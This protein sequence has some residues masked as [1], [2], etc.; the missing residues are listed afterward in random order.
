LENSPLGGEVLATF[1]RGQQLLRHSFGNNVAR[2]NPAAIQ[3]RPVASAQ[4][5]ISRLA[6]Q[7]EQNLEGFYRDERNPT[8]KNREWEKPEYRQLA[9]ATALQEAGVS[10]SQQANAVVSALSTQWKARLNAPQN[11]RQAVQ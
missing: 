10:T 1:T 4:T 6:K 5:D 9:L 2:G 3:N 7:V 11:R 8:M